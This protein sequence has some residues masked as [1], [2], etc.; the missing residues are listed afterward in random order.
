M[1]MSSMHVTPTPNQLFLIL[2]NKVNFGA[3]ATNGIKRKVLLKKNS[4]NFLFE[5]SRFYVLL[6]A[7]VYDVN[8]AKF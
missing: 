1:M 5:S 2:R 8:R 7:N 3:F 4:H 6:I